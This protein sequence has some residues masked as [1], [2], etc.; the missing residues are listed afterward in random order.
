MEITSSFANIVNSWERSALG[1]SSLYHL[2]TG[3]EHV[4]STLGEC[5]SNTN[6]HPN[7]TCRD[8]LRYAT[9]NLDPRDVEGFFSRPVAL[10]R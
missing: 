1:N 8:E 5:Y 6:H 3:L 9:L 7:M 4:G 10:S 2:I